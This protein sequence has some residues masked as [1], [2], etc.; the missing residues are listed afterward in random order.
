MRQDRA[1]PCLVL[2]GP[3]EQVPAPIVSLPLA[4]LQ[5][6]GILCACDA[7]FKIRFYSIYTAQGSHDNTACLGHQQKTFEFCSQYA[8]SHVIMH[9][10]SKLI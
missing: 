1:I 3:L 5:V 8:C 9:E 4:C 10:V 7:L 6:L 2:C